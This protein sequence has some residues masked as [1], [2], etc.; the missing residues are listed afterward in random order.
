MTTSAGHAF[1]KDNSVCVFCF[2]QFI[3]RPLKYYTFISHWFVCMPLLNK[4]MMMK[5]T[6]LA[7]SPADLHIH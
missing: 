7:F 4:P 6:T 3:P 1:S 5:P 2:Y